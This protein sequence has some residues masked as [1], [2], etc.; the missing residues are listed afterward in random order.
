MGSACVHE[1][2]LC[3]LFGLGKMMIRSNRRGY[4]HRSK[5][6]EQNKQARLSRY[7]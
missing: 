1:T 5:I 4:K 6:I 7:A 3:R 2:L